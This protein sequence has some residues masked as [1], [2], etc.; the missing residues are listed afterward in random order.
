MVQTATRRRFVQMMGPLVIGT[1][2]AGCSA[3]TADDGDTGGGPV[4]KTVEVT[5]DLVFDPDELSISAGDTIIW[6]N[7]GSVQHSVTAYGDQIPDGAEYF[8]SGGFDSE[9][10]ARD[11]F[12]DG[13]IGGGGSFRHTFETPGSYEY[14]CIPHEGAGMIGAIEVA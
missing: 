8:A 10:A 5:D 1:S 14:F 3:P 11:A 9:Q 6:E 13:A 4:T 2:L 12:P 7:V